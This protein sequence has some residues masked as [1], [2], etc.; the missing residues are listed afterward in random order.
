MCRLDVGDVGQRSLAVFHLVGRMFSMTGNALTNP[1]GDEQPYEN[2]QQAVISQHSV[3][4][5]LHNRRRETLAVTCQ[6]FWVVR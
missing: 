3:H 5:G 6:A 1:E 4:G 2:D